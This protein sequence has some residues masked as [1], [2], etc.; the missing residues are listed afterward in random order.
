MKAVTNNSII[1]ALVR[2]TK[3]RKEIHKKWRIVLAVMSIITDMT[4]E[5]L[6]RWKPR[7][8][9]ASVDIGEHTLQ[10]IR[11][12]GGD[13]VVDRVIAPHRRRTCWRYDD[14]A[15]QMAI[16]HPGRIRKNNMSAKDILLIQQLYDALPEIIEAVDSSPACQDLGVA[17]FFAS[18]E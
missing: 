1:D 14:E 11:D 7:Q 2:E 18:D 10:L 16:D 8:V 15:I 5:V 13:G 6:S 3:E 12:K 9:I 17:E 4:G